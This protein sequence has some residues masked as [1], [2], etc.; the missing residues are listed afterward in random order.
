MGRIRI[1]HTA[2]WHLGHTLL[3]QGREHEHACFLRWLIDQIEAHAVDVLIVAGDVFDG[4]SPSGPVQAAYFGF[5][6]SLV[7]R[8]PAVQVVIVA[9]NHDS[10][11]KLASTGPVLGMLGVHVVGAAALGSAPGDLS[12]T[13]ET[14]GG[15]VGIATVPFLRPSDLRAG[16]GLDPGRV[17]RAMASLYGE[18]VRITREAIGP[19][20]PLIATGHTHL[21]GAAVSLKSERLLFGG[22]AGAVGAEIFPNDCAYVALGHLHLSQTVRGNVGQVGDDTST[23]IVRYSGSPIPLALAEDAYHHSVSL[24]ELEGRRVVGLEELAVPRAVEMIRLHRES[25]DAVLAA[26]EALPPARDLERK[27]HPWLEVRAP[28]DA[29]ARTGEARARVEAALADR[30]AR[31]V[32]LALDRPEAGD[33]REEEPAA[34]AQHDVRTV[35][36]GRWAQVRQ[37]PLPERHRAALELA[38]SRAEQTVAEAR[39]KQ[40]ADRMGSGELS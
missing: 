23:P 6:A 14:P 13:L 36:Q 4:R 19:D 2:D 35:V 20:A 24:V 29:G 33:A 9:G 15:R 18:V 17:E 5:L 37:T 25:L 38:V 31:L 34:L 16:D 30:A 11:S 21:R 27:T 8:A 32:R 22:E 7:K 12:L 40:Q 26:I 10:P 1:L 3:G 28:I 39:Q